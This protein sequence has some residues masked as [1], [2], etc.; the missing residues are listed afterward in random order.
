MSYG[1]AKV[2]YDGSHYIA[3]PKTTRPVVERTKQYDDFIFV[4]DFKL[5]DEEKS[6]FSITEGTQLSL[7]DKENIKLEEAVT[8]KE[9]DSK[10]KIEPKPVIKQRMTKRELFNRLYREYISLPRYKLKN[11]IVA[12]MQQYFKTLENT[13]S[14]VEQHLERKKRNLISRRIRCVRKMNLQDFN[15]FVT[16]TYD[17]KLH[18]EDTF[19]K[20]LR[21]CLS[22]LATRKGWKYI[23]VWERSPQKKRLHFHGIFYI[24]QDTMPGIMIQK[25]DYSFNTRKRQITN[26]NTYFNDNFG[27][28]SFETIDCKSRLFDAAAY[29][30]KYLEKSGERIVYSK[31][32]PQYFISDIMDD[33]VVCRIGQEDKKLLLF[34]NFKCWDEGCLMGQVSKDTI[35]KMRKSN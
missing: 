14:Y 21:V 20:K 31:G 5:K 7:F 4:E 8:I 15:Y 12:Q 25:E 28:S 19:S 11:A 16:F 22:R 26:Q 35:N 3:I 32:L 33:D 34:D 18:T 13:V 1:E 2:Y 17:D 24:P 23:G 30:L 10:V 6:V 29:I 9:K 27:R